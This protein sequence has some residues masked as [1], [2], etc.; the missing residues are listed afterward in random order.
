MIE[1]LNFNDK[2]FTG[3]ENKRGH[4]SQLGFPFL[5]LKAIYG[6]FAEVYLSMINLEKLL[7]I[8]YGT[9]LT[10]FLNKSTP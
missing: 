2:L 9:F 5:N 1:K 7:E 8:N 10:L 4:N 3:S 6:F